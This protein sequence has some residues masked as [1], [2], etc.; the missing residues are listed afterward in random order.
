[1][2]FCGTDLIGLLVVVDSG[3]HCC[4]PF[5]PF[6]YTRVIDYFR[7]DLKYRGPIWDDVTGV[8]I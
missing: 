8:I 6:P 3:C 5:W 2:H 7:R 4:T 1:M